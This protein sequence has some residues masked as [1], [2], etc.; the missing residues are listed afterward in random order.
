MISPSL[1]FPPNHDQVQAV[2]KHYAAAYALME[3]LQ[4]PD[5]LPQEVSRL[6]PTGDQKTGCIGEY[7][8]MRFARKKFGPVQCHFGH[9]SQQGWDIA[10]RG[11]QTR[12]QIK[13]VSEWSKTRTLSPIHAQRERPDNAPADWAP[14]T[15][16]WLVYLNNDLF[17]IGFWQLKRKHVDFGNKDKLSGLKIRR[18]TNDSSGSECITWPSNT[19]S[20]LL[21]G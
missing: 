3:S 20:E 11:A 17:P 2:F 21:N 13:T 15:D 10:V 4:N 5:P 6:L 9:H 1:S 19:V 8:A 7:W 14:W 18:P 12:V 16:L